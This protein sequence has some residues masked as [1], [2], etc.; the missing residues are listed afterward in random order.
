MERIRCSGRRQPHTFSP[1]TTAVG[2]GRRAAWLPSLK[3]SID[4][5]AALDLTTMQRVAGQGL[6]KNPA[7]LRRSG[8]FKDGTWTELD[9]KTD[10]SNRRRCHRGQDP[11]QHRRSRSRLPKSFREHSGKGGRLSEGFHRGQ[12]AGF[13]RYRIYARRSS[14]D[15]LSLRDHAGG[16]ADRRRSEGRDSN[17]GRSSLRNSPKM[18]VRP[19]E[20]AAAHQRWRAMPAPWWWPTFPLLA[21]PPSSFAAKPM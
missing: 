12:Y 21:I 5:K 6:R 11:Q 13:R 19:D 4:L 1:P 17:A 7:V 18:D 8:N 20:Q 16:K 9:L 15:Q 10:E 2:D 3:K 14:I